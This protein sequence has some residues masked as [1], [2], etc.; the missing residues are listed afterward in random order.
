MDW[1]LNY[2]STIVIGAILLAV[3]ALIIRSMRKKKKTGESSC[4]CGCSSCAMKESC[5]GEKQ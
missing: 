5:H 2:F 1:L 3:I 4:G